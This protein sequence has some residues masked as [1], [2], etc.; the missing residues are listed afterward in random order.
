MDGKWMAFTVH[1]TS[2][3]IW[4]L[5]NFKGGLKGE[6]CEGSEKSARVATARFHTAGF[7]CN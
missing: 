5:A 4:N 1:G 6:F 3:K 7:F 2:K